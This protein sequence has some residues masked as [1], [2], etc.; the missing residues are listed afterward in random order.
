M[1]H[2]EAQ[3]ECRFMSAAEE[4]LTEQAIDDRAADI[5]DQIL[6]DPNAFQDLLYELLAARCK[7]VPARLTDLELHRHKL[8]VECLNAI[9]K[10]HATHFRQIMLREA[11]KEGRRRAEQEHQDG[12]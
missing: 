10:G 2:A 1:N 5:A 4:A 3:Y 6:A 12:I 7:E 9:M 11:L 8:A